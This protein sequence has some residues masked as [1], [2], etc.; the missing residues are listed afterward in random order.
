M[1]LAGQYCQMESGICQDMH[2][3]P[4][5]LGSSS[6]SRALNWFSCDVG[7]MQSSMFETRSSCC[8]VPTK[9]NHTAGCYHDVM[10]AHFTPHSAV[11][12]Y[13]AGAD[14]LMSGIVTHLRMCEAS[15]DCKLW[16][17]I[18][19]HHHGACQVLNDA[20]LTCSQLRTTCMVRI[21]NFHFYQ[22]GQKSAV[23]CSLLFH[24]WLKTYHKLEQSLNS[25]LTCN[26]LEFSELTFLPDG[27]MRSRH[28]VLDLPSPVQ[29]WLYSS[30]TLCATEGA[31]AALLN[32]HVAHVPSP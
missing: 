3:K 20:V 29:Y 26:T 7:Q 16:P 32:F 8:R 28:A 18:K 17:A 11:K 13:R 10:Y 9:S 14:M 6:L 30:Q 25:R 19:V 24:H 31:A 15:G 5:L 1:E 2:L 21:D 27:N 23:C 22:A 12:L 4:E